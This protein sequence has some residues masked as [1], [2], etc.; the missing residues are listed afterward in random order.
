MFNKIS[1]PVLRSLVFCVFGLF[2]A[3]SLNAK[4]GLSI[5]T[6]D[7]GFPYKTTEQN[8]WSNQSL[9]ADSLVSSLQFI[10]SEALEW[11]HRRF[12]LENA[13][14]RQRLFYL[15]I[16][17]QLDLRF[18]TASS[19]TLGHEMAHFQAFQRTGYVDMMFTNEETG[20]EVGLGEVFMNLFWTIN[21]GA[22]ASARLPTS[23][24]NTGTFNSGEGLNLQ[25]WFAQTRAQELIWQDQSVF[26]ANN[27]LANKFIMPIYSF[28]DIGDSDDITQYIT[29]VNENTSSTISRADVRTFALLSLALS[30]TTWSYFRGYRDYTRGGTLT[31]QPIGFNAFGRDVYWDLPVY[32]SNNG[33]NLAPMLYWKNNDPQSAWTGAFDKTMFGF[34]FETTVRGESKATDIGLFFQGQFKEKTTLKSTINFRSGQDIYANFGLSYA[35]RDNVELNAMLATAQGDTFRGATVLPYGDTVFGVGITITDF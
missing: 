28:L 2:C 32:L 16:A 25:S 4:E 9:R 10:G 35:L 26:A 33:I 19:I 21:P 20:A 22:V 13:T 27:Y 14:P 7:F 5:G 8:N 11:G 30:P 3:A 15:L 18:Q 1:P 29:F 24:T 6:I 31:A 34:G 23:T 12:D 17:G